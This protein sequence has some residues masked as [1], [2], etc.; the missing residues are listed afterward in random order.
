MIRFGALVVTT[1]IAGSV[2]LSTAVGGAAAAPETPDFGAAIDA[3][4]ENEPQTGCTDQAQKGVVAFRSMLNT[5]YE[6]HTGYITRGCGVG[7]TSEHKEGRALDYMLDVNDREENAIANDALNWLLK[8]DRHGNKHANARRLGIMYIIWNRKIW[9][10]YNPSAGWRDYGGSNPHT[11]HIHF[12]FSWAGARKQTTWWTASS[13]DRPQ[14]VGD[15]NGDGQTDRA[16]FRPSTGEWRIQYYRTN[17]TAVFDWGQAGD[18]PVPG[19][20]NGDG[21]HDRAV[22]RPSTGEWWVQYYRTNGTAKYTWGEP[23]DI[24]VPGDYNGDG[25]HDRV[26][27][28]PSTGEWWVQ[29]YGSNGTAKYT[30]GEPGDIPV[31]GDYNGDGQHDRVVFRP[32]TGEW[33]VQYYRTNGTAKYTWGQAGD[34]PAPGDYNG[35]GQHDRAVFRPSTGEWRIQYY[36]TNGTAVW[37]WGQNGDRPVTT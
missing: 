2:A 24:P 20:Y 12:S 18:I 35:D 30:W 31:P 13:D 22:F 11:D 33:W 15:Y 16:V 23:G 5:A 28:R 9:G 34:I 14:V 27:F 21:Q 26:V 17:G 1:A 37:D 3:Y 32:S 6:A 4:A 8:T 36:G 7:G 25:Q 29:Y 19:D 10:S